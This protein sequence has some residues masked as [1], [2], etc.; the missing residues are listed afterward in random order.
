MEEENQSEKKGVVVGSIF[1]DGGG[2]VVVIVTMIVN[3]GIVGCGEL[4]GEICRSFA[5]RNYSTLVPA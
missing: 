4:R 5:P 3:F 1:E 2:I